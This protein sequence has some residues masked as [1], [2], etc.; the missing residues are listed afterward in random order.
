MGLLRNLRGA[1]RRDNGSRREFSMAKGIYFLREGRRGEDT[2]SRFH[3]ALN[4]LDLALNSFPT[5]L[6]LGLKAC[7]LLWVTFCYCVIFV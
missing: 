6:Q 1:S 5:G 3:R 2:F 4:V 7:H